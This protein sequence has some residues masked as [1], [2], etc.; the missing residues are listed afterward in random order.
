MSESRKL[1]S[2]R[3][4]QACPRL[5]VEKPLP[6]S[7]TGRGD[8][9]IGHSSSGLIVVGYMGLKEGGTGTYFDLSVEEA[10]WFLTEIR[11]E[12]NLLENAEYKPR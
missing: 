6:A 10:E 8:L 4:A 5:L 3:V 9:I 11:R 7:L 1:E 2:E 12:L